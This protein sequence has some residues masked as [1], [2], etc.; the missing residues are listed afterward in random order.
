MFFPLGVV[1]EIFAIL[2]QKMGSMYITS[3][4]FRRQG[5]V[6]A[7]LSENYYRFFLENPTDIFRNSILGKFDILD[8]SHS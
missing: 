8:L 3:F 4:I 2:E 1:V 7:Q 6:L 5:M